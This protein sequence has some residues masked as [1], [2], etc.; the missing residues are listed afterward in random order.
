MSGSREGGSET[1]GGTTRRS[2]KKASEEGSGWKCVFITRGIAPP[3]DAGSS[4]HGS[5]NGSEKDPSPPFDE[6][7]DLWSEWGV[8]V[9]NWEAESKKR[10]QHIRVRKS[11]AKKAQ[12]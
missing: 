1:D 2:G 8:I 7:T 10:S 3:S 9:K 4:N 12:I 5:P 6:E 11:R